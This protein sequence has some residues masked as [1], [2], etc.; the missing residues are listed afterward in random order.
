MNKKG[1][2]LYRTTLPFLR[3]SVLNLNYGYNLIDALTSKRKNYV[4]SLNFYPNFY[5]NQYY[6]IMKIRL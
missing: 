4:T 5:E 3:A 1:I 2:T 6:A